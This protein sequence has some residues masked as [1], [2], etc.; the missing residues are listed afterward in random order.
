MLYLT[1]SQY[2][3]VYLALTKNPDSKSKQTKTGTKTTEDRSQQN[4]TSV[5]V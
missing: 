5:G 2:Y 1:T 3:Q 4:P